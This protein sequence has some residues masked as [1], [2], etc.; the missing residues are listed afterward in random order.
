M[1]M[2][3]L[4]DSWFGEKGSTS[5]ESQPFDRIK[6]WIIV[7]YSTYHWHHQHLSQIWHHLHFSV[8][9]SPVCMYCNE[10][11][12]EPNIETCHGGV[13]RWS[14]RSTP[15]QLIPN[16]LLNIS[17]LQLDFLLPHFLIWQISI[18]NHLKI[19][20]ELYQSLI[21]KNKTSSKMSLFGK[22]S[23]DESLSGMETFLQILLILSFIY[24]LSLSLTTFRPITFTH[25]SVQH[26]Y[27]RHQTKSIWGLIL[28]NLHS[29]WSIS[30]TY[31]VE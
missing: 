6:S 9:R 26:R 16:S 21:R 7:L 27:T 11:V 12:T 3:D 17:N 25:L 20:L 22:R 10:P 4:L 5:H 19:T 29:L 1:M 2:V 31:L 8:I 28:L 23:G 13:R 24:S 18:T 30:N 14:H 15:L